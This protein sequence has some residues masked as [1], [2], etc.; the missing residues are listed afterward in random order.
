LGNIRHLSLRLILLENN[1]G[2]AEKEL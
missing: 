2:L 1:A